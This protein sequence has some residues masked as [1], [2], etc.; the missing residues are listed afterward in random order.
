MIG[1]TLSVLIEMVETLAGLQIY[2]SDLGMLSFATTMPKGWHQRVK[3]KE[4][5]SSSDSS[6]TA[7]AE[8][9]WIPLSR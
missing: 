8:S 3:I 6:V 9:A 1:M 2:P 4:Q 7:Y 5:T